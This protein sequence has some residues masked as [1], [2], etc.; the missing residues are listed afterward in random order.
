MYATSTELDV[1]DFWRD[2]GIVAG[3][4][5]LELEELVSVERVFGA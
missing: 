3:D 4:L 2:E 1:C 5:E